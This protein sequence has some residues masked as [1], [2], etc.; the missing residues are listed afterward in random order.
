LIFRNTSDLYRSSA[1]TIFLRHI[2]SFLE[3]LDCFVRTTRDHVFARREYTCCEGERHRRQ[4]ICAQKGVLVTI[5]ENPEPHHLTSSPCCFVPSFVSVSYSTFYACQAYLYPHSDAIRVLQCWPPFVRCPLCTTSRPCPLSCAPS[6]A[7]WPHRHSPDIF[8]SPLHL[9]YLVILY[10]FRFLFP[11][12]L[13]ASPQAFTPS[14]LMSL[15][16]PEYIRGCFSIRF[17][18]S[19]FYSSLKSIKICVYVPFLYLLQDSCVPLF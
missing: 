4:R 15:D 10:C 12:T 16:P 19:A 5:D 13:W 17:S 6:G 7:T 11:Q 8:G 18:R 1:N 2:R 14:L 3:T 9:C